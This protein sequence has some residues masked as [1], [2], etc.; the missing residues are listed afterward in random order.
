MTEEE[1]LKEAIGQ[2]KKRKPN[3]AERRRKPTN[4]PWFTKATHK[5]K[6]LRSRNAKSKQQRKREIAELRKARKESN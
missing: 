1:E 3:R 6:K 2:E 5:Y 4:D